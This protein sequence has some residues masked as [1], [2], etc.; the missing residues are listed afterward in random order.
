MQRGSN[1]DDII[2]VDDDVIVDPSFAI[3]INY[4]REIIVEG[5]IYKYQ[6]KG[7]FILQEERIDEFRA[8]NAR[9]AQLNSSYND[10]HFGFAEMDY[11]TTAPDESSNSG[12]GGY[13]FGS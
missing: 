2:E 3:L 8:Y 9:D 7:V 6:D 11:L 5:K 4:N 1:S 10:S 12:G 13:G